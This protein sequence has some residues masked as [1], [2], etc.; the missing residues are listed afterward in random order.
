MGDLPNKY[1]SHMT[2]SNE[3]QSPNPV[4]NNSDDGGPYNYGRSLTQVNSSG[5]GS[6]SNPPPS[7]Y[8]PMNQFPNYPPQSTMFNSNQGYM[9]N[10]YSNY[11]Q[12]FP[13]NPNQFGGVG[14]GP[15]NQYSQSSYGQ[16]QFSGP[17]GYPPQQFNNYPQ[18]Q[19]FY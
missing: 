13:P 19:R 15:P 1:S 4:K 8:P 10:G 18:Q 9:N 14:G 6:S 12:G 2:S 3:G 11:N 5:T 16:N 17:P 7:N